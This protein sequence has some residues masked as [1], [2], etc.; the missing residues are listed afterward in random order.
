MKNKYRETMDEYYKKLHAQQ[1]IDII[2]QGTH[3]SSRYIHEYI[4]KFKKD[5][6]NGKFK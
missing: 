3:Y 4:D 5:K 1:V 6:R 2:F